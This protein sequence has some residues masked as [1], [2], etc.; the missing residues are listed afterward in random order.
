MDSLAASSARTACAQAASAVSALPEHA[1]LRAAALWAGSAHGAACAQAL[2]PR[3]CAGG[4]SSVVCTS[5]MV[6]VHV[7]CCPGRVSRCGHRWHAQGSAG[8]ASTLAV[9]SVQH[10]VRWQPAWAACGVVQW[11]HA[12]RAAC[13]GSVLAGYTVQRAQATLRWATRCPS[14]Q[15]DVCRWH[16]RNAQAVYTGQCT[17]S[18][19]SAVC[20]GSTLAVRMGQAASWQHPGS[21]QCS[22][23][24]PWGRTLAGRCVQAAWGNAQAVWGQQAASAWG[25]ALVACSVQHAGSVRAALWQCAAH[26]Q[27]AGSGGRL[28]GSALADCSV[29]SRQAGT[30][31]VGMGQAAGRQRTG[32]RL[33]CLGSV[34]HT[35]RTLHS[36]HV[37]H[38]GSDPVPGSLPQASPAARA[39]SCSQHPDAAPIGQSC[40]RPGAH[41]WHGGSSVLG[42]VACWAGNE[43][44]PR[45]QVGPT[46][47]GGRRAGC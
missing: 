3:L 36:P 13:V 42:G 26:W 15:W 27:H 16:M 47:S 5:T 29:Q 4:T 33:Q 31:T 22:M 38:A 40:G 35:G 30:L 1:G 39:C 12:Q 25:S 34:V 44:H 7:R 10:S 24:R 18:V 17:G 11:Q 23:G 9:S 21:A 45:L 46:G 32:R 41:V 8:A 37:L 6:T 20:A 19:L 2:H 43:G 14:A 28:R